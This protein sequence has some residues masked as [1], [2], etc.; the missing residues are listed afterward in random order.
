MPVDQLELVQK[1]INCR[2]KPIKKVIFNV[3]YERRLL[4]D[5]DLPIDEILWANDRG[6]L[7]NIDDVIYN[8][9]SGL[10]DTNYGIGYQIDD[11][12]TSLDLVHDIMNLRH[13]AMFSEGTLNSVNYDHHTQTLTLEY[14][15]E[16]G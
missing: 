12:D 7:L 5:D 9:I 1:L 3:G 4:D 10:T 16:S 13:C 8:K 2:Y 15:T 11:L 14:D 6:I